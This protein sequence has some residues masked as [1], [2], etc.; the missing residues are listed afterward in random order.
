VLKVLFLQ[1]T[2]VAYKHKWNEIKFHL[3]KLV[4]D[5]LITFVLQMYLKYVGYEDKNSIKLG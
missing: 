5:N 4:F 3:K 2:W 1:I